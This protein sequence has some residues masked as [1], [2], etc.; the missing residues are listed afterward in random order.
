MAFQPPTS[1]FAVHRTAGLRTRH[2]RLAPSKFFGLPFCAS[3]SKFLP[4]RDKLQVFLIAGA[5][6]VLIANPKPLLLIGDCLLTRHTQPIHPA[7]SN[8]SGDYAGR[9]ETT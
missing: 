7:L 1:L 8:A 9:R 4:R 6:H 5:M 2:H 3:A